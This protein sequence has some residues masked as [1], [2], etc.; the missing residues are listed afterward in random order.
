MNST[1]TPALLTVYLLPPT[2]LCPASALVQP[3][4][5]LSARAV[6]ELLLQPSGHQRP[7]ERG[8][9]DLC[10]ASSRSGPRAQ[11]LITKWTA[12]C[13][14]AQGARLGGGEV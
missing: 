12:L 8:T 4:L 13:F 5:Q 1:P 11:L 9:Q 10:R 6:T 7:Q 2:V 14:L 3:R